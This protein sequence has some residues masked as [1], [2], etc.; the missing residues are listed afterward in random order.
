MLAALILAVLELSTAPGHKPNKPA[1]SRWAKLILD[2]STRENEDPFLVSAIISRESNYDPNAINVNTGAAGLM[3]VMQSSADHVLLGWKLARTKSVPAE[4]VLE[5][6]NNLRIGIRILK[7]HKQLCGGNLE[8]ALSSYNGQGCVESDFA[9]DV[10][11]RFERARIF[12]RP[13]T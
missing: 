13:T 7:R 12:W 3:Q 1:A 11:R 6:R 4:K 10:I 2:V 5:P 8:H 9:K